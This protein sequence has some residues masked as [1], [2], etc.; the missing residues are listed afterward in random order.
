MLLSFVIPAHNEEYELGGALASI[1]AAAATVPHVHEIIVADDAS[2]DRTA[3]IAL[4]AGARVVRIE[5]RQIAAARNA[6]AREARGDVLFFIDADT[7]IFPEHIT[8]ALGALKEGCVGGGAR[9]HIADKIP[10]WAKVF[11]AV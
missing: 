2:A 1:H 4:A 8:G 6:G 11:L 5:R 3:E 10:L 9:I 7:H